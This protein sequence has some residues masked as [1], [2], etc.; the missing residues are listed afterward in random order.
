[1]SRGRPPKPTALKK[2][3]G[4][5]RSDQALNN[6]MSPAPIASI[7]AAP[8]FLGDAGTREWYIVLSN[9][10]KLNML[11]P[12]DLPMIAAYCKEIE[13]YIDINKQ[14]TDKIRTIT[15]KNPDGSVKNVIINPLVKIA[16]ESLEKAMKIAVQCGLTP[17]SRTRIAVSQINASSNAIDDEFDI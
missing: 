9:Y 13:R 17:A 8:D 7:P 12:L 15:L 1:M 6:E 10:A 2:L 16:S 11:S 14:L 3:Q 4:T 5:Y